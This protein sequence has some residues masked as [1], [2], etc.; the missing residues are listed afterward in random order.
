MRGQS[1]WPI[2]ST[3]LVID[4]QRSVITGGYVA[5]A[6]HGRSVSFATP[7]PPIVWGTLPSRPGS[8]RW[9]APECVDYG[10]LIGCNRGHRALAVR[11]MS[12]DAV[13]E[14]T[15]DRTHLRRAMTG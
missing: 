14:F 8:G 13:C 1:G 2:D 5:T 12:R 7:V 6:V 4:G 9:W 3:H 15:T 10:A 11:G